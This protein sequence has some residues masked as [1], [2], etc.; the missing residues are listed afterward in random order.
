MGKAMQGTLGDDPDAEAL[1]G[2]AVRLEQEQI[3]ERV[4]SQDQYLSA[5]GGFL[6]LRFLQG[7]KVVASAVPATGARLASLRERLMIFYTGQ[8]RP[9]HDLL[10]EQ[11]GNIRQ[12]LIDQQLAVMK[13][14]VDRGLDVLSGRSPLE[15]F[16]ELLD[17]GWM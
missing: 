7:G 12:G 15:E 1:A 2:E 17:R 10:E 8:Q 9:A 5:L 3:G 13:S 4:G 6:H 16:G 11:L 14:L